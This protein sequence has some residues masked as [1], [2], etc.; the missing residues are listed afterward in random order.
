MTKQSFI[1]TSNGKHFPDEGTVSED[2]GFWISEVGLYGEV[3]EIGSPR[4]P[5]IT[6]R[7]QSSLKREGTA[8]FRGLHTNLTRTGSR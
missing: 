3:E 5:D 2:T 4:G 7:A 1:A 6:P 8:T